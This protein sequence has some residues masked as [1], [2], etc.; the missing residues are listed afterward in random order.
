MWHKNCELRHQ[1]YVAAYRSGQ[2]AARSTRRRVAQQRVR[3]SRFLRHLPRVV[4]FPRRTSGGHSQFRSQ[5]RVDE[6]VFFL[7]PFV[8]NHWNCSIPFSKQRK[9]GGCQYKRGSFLAT[10]HRIGKI[11]SRHFASGSLCCLSS[12]I[13][14]QKVMVSVPRK[15]FACDVW[16]TRIVL[17][18]VDSVL[19]GFGERS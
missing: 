11:G 2:V 8:R 7:C 9:M 6:P 16:Q 10:A 4:D 5:S 18:Y 1:S 19:F 15:V 14:A 3:P 12:K 17:I 13:G